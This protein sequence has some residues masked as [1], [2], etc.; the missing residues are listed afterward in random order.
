MKKVL[1]PLTWDELYIITSMFENP[2]VGRFL[3]REE[4]I[5]WK[6]LEQ[7]C[8]KAWEGKD[9]GKQH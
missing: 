6:K 1:V 8:S 7:Y 2:G 4:E 9:E 5:L 3:D